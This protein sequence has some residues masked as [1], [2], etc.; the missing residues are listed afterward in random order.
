M[1]PKKINSIA[2]FNFK[3]DM[4]A[5]VP[6]GVSNTLPDESM[7]I[8]TILERYSRGLS[9]GGVVKD[10]IYLDDEDIE[11]NEGIDIKKLDL[12]EIEDLHLNNKSKIRSINEQLKKLNDEKAAKKTADVVTQS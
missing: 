2:T 4:G 6:K 9:L 12:A 7:S 10:A 8:R 1:N 3:K 11:D 5:H